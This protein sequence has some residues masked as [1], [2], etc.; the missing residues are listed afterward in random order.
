[1]QTNQNDSDVKKAFQ[2]LYQ[3]RWAISQSTVRERKNKLERLKNVI[4]KKR[5]DILNA[6]YKDLRH[7]KPR[8]TYKD[9]LKPSLAVIHID[10]IEI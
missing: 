1:M 6:L 4:I 2:E 3:N 8:T 5:E 10:L 7:L 9:V